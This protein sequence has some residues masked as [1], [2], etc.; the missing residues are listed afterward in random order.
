MKKKIVNIL[1]AV[2]EIAVL[3]VFFS[4]KGTVTVDSGFH[5]YEG[6]VVSALNQIVVYA[7]PF[8]VL[9][10]LNLIMCVCSVLSKSQKRDGAMHAAL[11]I[12]LFIFTNWCILSLVEVANN[13]LLLQLLMFI[14]I[15]VAFIKRSR[16]IVGETPTAVVVSNV[17]TSSADEL[18]KYKELLDSGVISQEEFDV[19]KKQLLDM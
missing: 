17:Q 3:A 6:T 5:Y 18:K 4:M 15:L 10:G 9:W 16:V 11:P 2:I 13:F 12:L 8:Y 7:V 1:E 19:K 14:L